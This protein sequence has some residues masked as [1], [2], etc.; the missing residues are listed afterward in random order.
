M[1]QNHKTQN[2]KHKPQEHARSLS[3]LLRLRREGDLRFQVL[4]RSLLLLHLG[5]EVLLLLLRSGSGL[6]LRR[7]RHLQTQK[8]LSRRKR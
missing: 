7:R 4:L 6:L 5:L 2:T 8:R 3:L 1:N